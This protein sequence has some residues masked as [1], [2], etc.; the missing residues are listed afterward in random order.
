[1]DMIIYCIE[2]LYLFVTMLSAI[3]PTNSR[4]PIYCSAN[5]ERIGA[6]TGYRLSDGK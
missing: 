4:R 6:S 3:V 2:K 1:M 5:L